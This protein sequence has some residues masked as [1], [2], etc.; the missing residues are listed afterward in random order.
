MQIGLCSHLLTITDLTA[1]RLPAANV[2]KLIHHIWVCDDGWRTKGSEQQRG[3][4]ANSSAWGHMFIYPTQLDPVSAILT[5]CF[6]L[7][8]S[9]TEKPL[10]ARHKWE[11]TYAKM[12]CGPPTVN[13]SCPSC[14]LNWRRP[15]VHSCVTTA[16]RYGQLCN[17]RR[18]KTPVRFN[19]SASPVWFRQALGSTVCV[20]KHLFT[21]VKRKLI[22][23]K[24]LFKKYRAHLHIHASQFVCS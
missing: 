19:M 10:K 22:G 17:E 15:S 1:H 2:L 4:R 3:Q 20:K 7:F 18:G 23:H 13:L 21:P 11:I 14:V 8:H 9:T 24:N 6:D 5:R 12:Y 16:K